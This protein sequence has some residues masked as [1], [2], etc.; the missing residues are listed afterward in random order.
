MTQTCTF[1]HKDAVY[2]PLVVKAKNGR[3]THRVFEVYY[4]YDCKAEYV[5]F[6]NI[7]NHHLYTTINNRMYR[8]SVEIDGA[9]GRL[10]YVG[11][12]GEPGVTPN[13][14]MELVKNFHAIYPA[15]TPGNIQEKLKFILLF[16]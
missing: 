2:V 16:L 12:P 11:E 8:W 6:G 1:C 4:C 15:I 3:S 10:W 14:K 5:H 13:R 7:K 9:M